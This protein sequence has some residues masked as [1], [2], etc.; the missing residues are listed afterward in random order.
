MLAEVPIEE[1]PGRPKII[2]SKVTLPK[3]KI[4][5]TVEETKTSE[6]IEDKCVAIKLE[7]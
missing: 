3:L 2:F 6:K 7:I 5:Q 1:N 4:I